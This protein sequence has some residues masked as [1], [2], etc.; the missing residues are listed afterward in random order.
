MINL[1]ILLFGFSLVSSQI[2][3]CGLVYIKETPQICPQL[4]MA[5][6]NNT[7]SAVTV[8]DINDA[9]TAHSQRHH[10]SILGKTF[11]LIN[12]SISN[13]VINHS[14]LSRVSPYSFFN[15]IFESHTFGLL[16]VSQCCRWLL[17]P[18]FWAL[19]YWWKI[20]KDEAEWCQ[21]SVV[22]LLPFNTAE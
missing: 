15:S 22:A 13:G 14:S 11:L 21:F 5:V 20:R 8:T 18:S 17:L 6:N 2:D 12:S 9:V 16:Q 3:S 10:I 1:D 19:C 7:Q 4:G